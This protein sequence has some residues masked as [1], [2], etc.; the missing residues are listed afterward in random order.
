MIDLLAADS[1]GGRSC[2]NAAS[3]FR[4]VSFPATELVG[5]R[6]HN[7]SIWRARACRRIVAM[8]LAGG[9]APVT[10]AG[11]VTQH[12]AEVLAGITLHQLASA[13]SPVGRARA[14]FDMR[15]GGARWARWRPPC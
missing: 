15:T 8:P 1:A 7:C 10:L 3:D 11:S 9:P 13:G 12:A 6:S 14:I 2:G 4:C 5:I